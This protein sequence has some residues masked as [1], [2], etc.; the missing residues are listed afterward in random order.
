MERQKMSVSMIQSGV[1]ISLSLS[2]AQFHSDS[3]KGLGPTVASLS[4]GSAALMHF[5][6]H[7]DMENPK[8]K[9][10]YALTLVL[11]HVSVNNSLCVIPITQLYAAGRRLDYGG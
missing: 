6:R 7:V 11:R 8:A 1:T 10:P 4:L 9:S 2:Y 3:E 5:R